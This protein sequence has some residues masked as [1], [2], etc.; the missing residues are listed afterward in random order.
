MVSHTTIQ[1]LQKQYDQ[2]THVSTRHIMIIY[3]GHYPGLAPG[4]G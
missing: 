1:E 2:L 3:F 4:N